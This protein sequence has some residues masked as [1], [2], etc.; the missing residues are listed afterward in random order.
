MVKKTNISEPSTTVYS[1]IVPSDFR[2]PEE[3]VGIYV[4]VASSIYWAVAVSAIVAKIQVF[5][6]SK[7]CLNYI[8][9]D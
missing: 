9:S 6:F 3:A 2:F 4:T 1:P 8:L 7:F 5:M